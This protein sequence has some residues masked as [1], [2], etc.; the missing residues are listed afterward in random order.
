MY[1][2][3]L[4]DDDELEELDIHHFIEGS[5]SGFAILFQQHDLMEVSLPPKITSCYCHVKELMV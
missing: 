5:A 1:L 2:I 3:S 4:I